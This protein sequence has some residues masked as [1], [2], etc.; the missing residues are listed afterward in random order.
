M[1]ITTSDRPWSLDQFADIVRRHQAVVCATA[2]GVT[3]D[4]ALSE[5][6]AQEAFVAAWQRASTLRDP[7]KVGPW[8]R[9]IA[10][11]LALSARRKRAPHEPLGEH[12]AGDDVAR[13]AI[14]HD[15]A[16]VTWAALRELPEPYREALVLYYWE[17]QSARQVADAL[18]ISEATAMQRLSRG[19]ALLREEVQRRVEGTLRR[20]R[21][22]AALTTA[23]IA[24]IAAGTA[25]TA[26]AAAAVNAAPLRALVTW[27]TALA[28]I[29]VGALGTFGASMAVSSGCNGGAGA[30]AST[31]TTSASAPAA[32]PTTTANGE[33]HAA[34]SPPGTPDVS[35]AAPA[36][37]RDPAGQFITVQVNDAD[38]THPWR[39]QDVRHAL[40]DCFVSTLVDHPAALDVVV[41]SGTIASVAVPAFDGGTARILALTPPPTSTPIAPAQLAAAF[42]SGEQVS[43]SADA[44]VADNDDSL[45]LHDFV[46]LCAKT[47]LAGLAVSGPDTTHRLLLTG[48]RF[49]PNKVDHVAYRDLDVGT[50]ATRGPA[51]AKVTV[52]VFLDVVDRAGYGARALAAWDEVLADHAQDVR[53]VVKLCPSKTHRLAA[54]AA[55]AANAQGALWPMLELLAANPDQLGTDD[56]VADAAKLN[57]DVT[58]FRSDLD[59]HAYSEAVDL[60]QDQAITMDIHALPSAIVNGKRVHGALPASAYR[61][62]IDEA[63]ATAS[64]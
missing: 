63:L 20:G 34:S 62:A 22:G 21:P 38:P 9:G 26:G 28:A 14:A 40:A 12:T 1:T 44:I 30:Q 45:P 64:R 39:D 51:N 3:G 43:I 55:Y 54:E 48:S 23:I 47:R 5:D 18:A 24:A 33:H 29:V 41:H 59:A 60:D 17:D 2:F 10:R 58:R 61:A 36:D 13:D 53:L 52:V 7:A 16:R 27:K 50:G 31:G 4:R 56:L 35:L 19:R 25:K 57:L 8:L 6:I 42:A 37:E 46:E 32:T 15:E 49:V 11:N